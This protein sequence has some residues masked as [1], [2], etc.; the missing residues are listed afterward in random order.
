MDILYLFKNLFK[1]LI[2]CFYPHISEFDKKITNIDKKT[3]E[4]FIG[5]FKEKYIT[6]LQ[7]F[8]THI[9]NI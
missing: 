2:Y 7:K 4:E 6:P 1:Q 3:K 5:D 9:L 8:W